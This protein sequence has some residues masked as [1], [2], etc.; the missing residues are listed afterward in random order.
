MAQDTAFDKLSH[1]EQTKERL[2]GAYGD[3]KNVPRKR[4]KHAIEVSRALDAPKT[5]PTPKKKMRKSV[6]TKTTMR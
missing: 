6:G 2:K 3:L 4:Y 1:V 5:K